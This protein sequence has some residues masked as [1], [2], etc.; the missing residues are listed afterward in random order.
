MDFKGVVLYPR[1]PQP[2]PSFPAD[3][4]AEVMTVEGATRDD[5][6]EALID[7]DGDVFHAQLGLCHNLHRVLLNREIVRRRDAQRARQAWIG[8]CVL[9]LHHDTQRACSAAGSAKT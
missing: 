2:R 6:I 8:V 7:N 3:D 1:L 5:A 9:A 4:I